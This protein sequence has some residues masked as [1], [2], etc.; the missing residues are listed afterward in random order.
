MILAQ[1][2]LLPETARKIKA[3]ILASP[4]ARTFNW[5]RKRLPIDQRLSKETVNRDLAELNIVCNV[6]EMVADC[7]DLRKRRPA[8]TG[9]AKTLRPDKGAGSPDLYRSYIFRN[10]VKIPVDFQGLPANELKSPAQAERPPRRPTLQQRLVHAEALVAMGRDDEHAPYRL[11]VFKLARY[12]EIVHGWIAPLVEPIKLYT[13]LTG[14]N[15]ETAT[16]EVRRH[17]KN[18]RSARLIAPRRKSKK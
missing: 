3:E 17:L 8:S 5:I 18:L 6:A 10:G 7:L 1:R 9:R 2:D 15:D 14:K 4:R 11:L 16:R 12:F 13:A